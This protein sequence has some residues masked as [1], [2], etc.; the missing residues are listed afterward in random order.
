MEM[1]ATETSNP[2]RTRNAAMSLVPKESLIP[3]YFTTRVPFIPR[4]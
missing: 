4:S 1:T 3:F 2:T